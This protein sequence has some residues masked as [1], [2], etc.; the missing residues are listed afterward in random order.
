[1]KNIKLIILSIISF[2]VLAL[3]LQAELS[4]E[5]F[6]KEI[7]KPLQEDVWAEISGRITNISKDKGKIDGNLRVRIRFSSSALY[8]QI[9]LNESN[10]YA[11][12]QSQDE[13]GKLQSIFSMPDEEKGDKLFDFGLTAEDLSFSFIYWNFLEELPQQ[14]R[15]SRKCRV[16]KLEHPQ[17]K[18]FVE[19]FFDAA[20]G[21]PLTV[22]WFEN[23]AKKAWRKLEMKGAK[24]HENGL[25]FVKEMRLD[26]DKWKTR[27]IFDFASLRDVGR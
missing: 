4:A 16:M 27:V 14:R 3:K 9:V 2:T 5:D 6:L 22:Q 1:V 23:D 24:R 21:F 15:K 12:E 26:G 19:V 7:R 10:V 25:W 11:F 8:A 20:L 17:G 13:E 18:G